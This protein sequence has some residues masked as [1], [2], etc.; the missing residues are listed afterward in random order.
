MLKKITGTTILSSLVIASVAGLAVAATTKEDLAKKKVENITCE[1]FIG[2]DESFRPT[3][4]A[5]AT[6]YHQGHNKKPEDVMDIAGIERITPVLIA[7]CEKDPKASFWSKA[8]E[9]LQKK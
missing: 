5:W 8:N 6:G 3:M 1:D 7:V 9:E 2:L 4:I